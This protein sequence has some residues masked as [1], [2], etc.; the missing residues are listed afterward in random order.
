M[1]YLIWPGAGISLLGIVG[2]AYCIVAATKARSDELDPPAMEKRLQKLLALN[3]A[4]LAI[5][6]IGLMMVVIGILLG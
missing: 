2:I 1:T 5:S 3:M 4:A 6:S